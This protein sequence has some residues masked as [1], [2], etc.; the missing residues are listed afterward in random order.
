[1]KAVTLLSLCVG[2]CLALA[3]AGLKVKSGLPPLFIAAHFAYR[4]ACPGCRSLQ[5]QRRPQHPQPHCFPCFQDVT[6]PS[7]HFVQGLD[8]GLKSAQSLQIASMEC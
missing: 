3:I 1:M 6:N 8:V 5:G 7:W 2:A 4:A